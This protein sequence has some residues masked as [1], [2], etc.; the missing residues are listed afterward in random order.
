MLKNTKFYLLLL[1]V[2][3]LQT[4]ASAL[5]DEAAI[6]AVDIKPLGDNEYR[7][8]VTIKH[9]DTGWDHY[10]NG[11]EVFDEAGNSLGVRV[12]AHPHV[13]EQPF[14]RSL[15]LKIAAGIKTLTIVATDSVHGSN[16]ETF[17]IDVPQ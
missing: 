10:A 16:D 14:T 12:L 7:I 6:T 15:Q 13:N 8:S 5:A 1:L 11:W 9:A 3:I 17:T 2:S 4:P